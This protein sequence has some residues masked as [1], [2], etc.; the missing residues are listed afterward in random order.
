MKILVNTISTKK[1]A[2]GA[3]QIA[4]NF[5]LKTLHYEDENIDWYYIT[6]S[7]LHEVL[8]SYFKEIINSHYFVFPTQPDYLG[9]YYRVKNVLDKLKRIF[10][11]MLYIQ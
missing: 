7:D 5:L 10:I 4:Y 6:S 8:G 1:N 2:G 9:S 3:F 11:P